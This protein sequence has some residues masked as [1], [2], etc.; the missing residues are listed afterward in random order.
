MTA[1]FEIEIEV[2]HYTRSGQRWTVHHD[3]EVLLQSCRDPSHDAAR[4]LWARGADADDVVITRH[5]GRDG[6]CLTGTIG[7]L[8]STTTTEGDAVSVRTVPW[9]PYFGPDV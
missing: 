8:A 3:G 4:E 2:S 1:F 6:V 5:V 7:C 9:V